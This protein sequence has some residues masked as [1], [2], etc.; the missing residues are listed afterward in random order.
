MPAS[1]PSWPDINITPVFSY[2]WS[3]FHDVFSWAQSSYIVFFNHRVSY[4]EIVIFSMAFG[5]VLMLSPFGTMMNI[6]NPDMYE[7]EE[8]LEGLAGSSWFDDF[9]P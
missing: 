2:L 6:Y 9:S 4:A 8:E 1:I 3:L 7:D 5:M